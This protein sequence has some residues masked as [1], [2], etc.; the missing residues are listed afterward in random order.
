MNENINE[1]KIIIIKEADENVLNIDKTKKVKKLDVS[2]YTR[3]L[4][5]VDIITQSENRLINIRNEIEN[6]ESVQTD[7]K[8]KEDEINQNESKDEPKENKKGIISRG[9]DWI[10]GAFKELSLLFKSEEL[11]D[12]Y[13]AN[14]NL[15]KKPKNKIPY[16]SKQKTE[17]EIKKNVS[18]DIKSDTLNYVHDNINYG[19]LFN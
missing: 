11:I 2:K 10:S 1:N 17:D 4:N 19:A 3:N 5:N 9:V 14:G 8:E 12:A 13:D 18:D 16:K 7:L 6:K 15:V